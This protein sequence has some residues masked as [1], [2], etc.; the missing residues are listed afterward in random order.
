MIIYDFDVSRF[1]IVPA[2]TDA[3]LIVNPNTPFAFSITFQSLEPVTR[4]IPQ[5]GRGGS[6]I[7]LAQFA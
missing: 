6:R 2:E 1:P 4:W 7:E 3:P 5:I